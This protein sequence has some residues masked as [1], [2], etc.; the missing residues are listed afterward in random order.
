MT[1]PTFEGPDM[2]WM[3][4]ASCT[5]AEHIELPWIGE[6]NRVPR[7]TLTA[8]RVVCEQGPV[9]EQCQRYIVAADVTAGFWAGESRNHL[10]VCATQ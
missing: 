1:G 4:E 5:A 7:L 6:L 8:M 3:R 9:L 2:R 10:N